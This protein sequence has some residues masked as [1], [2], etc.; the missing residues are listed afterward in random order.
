MTLDPNNLFGGILDGYFAGIGVKDILIPLGFILWSLFLFI[1]INRIHK[2]WI[3]FSMYVGFAIFSA[4]TLIIAIPSIQTDHIGI[5]T[6]IAVVTN[7]ILLSLLRLW[8]IDR[9]RKEGLKAKQQEAL[10]G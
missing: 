5:K 10:N 8:F 3:V 6:S 1:P 4:V 2:D 9:K 7:A